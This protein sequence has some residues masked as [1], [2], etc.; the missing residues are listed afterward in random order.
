MAAKS[1][2]DQAPATAGNATTNVTQPTA[3]QPVPVGN[4]ESPVVHCSATA[5]AIWPMVVKSHWEQ[6]QPTAVCAAT[7]ATVP[8]ARQHVLVVCAE[9]CATA[10]KGTVMATQPMVAKPT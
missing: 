6:I 2:P 1:T 7:S 8:T 4:A 5:T 10:V 9:S 3:Q